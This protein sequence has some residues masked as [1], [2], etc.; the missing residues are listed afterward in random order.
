M[1]QIQ[2]LNYSIGER[3]LLKQVNWTIHPGRRIA[4]VGANG[5]GKTTLLRIL[6]GEI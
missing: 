1:L 6:C 5:A 2:N 4:L 3:D